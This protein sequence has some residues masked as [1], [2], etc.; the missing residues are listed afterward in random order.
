MKPTCMNCKHYKVEDALSGYCR[1]E[2]VQGSDNTGQK[3]MVRHDHN[4]PQ[5]ADCG[6]HYYIRLGWL[7]AQQGRK[8]TDTRQ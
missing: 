4:C 5:W 1:A 8:T 6:Q 7:K 2:K 3:A